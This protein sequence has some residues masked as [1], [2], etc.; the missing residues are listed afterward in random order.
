MAHTT[1]Y[2]CPVVPSVKAALA[3]NKHW[4]QC[5]LNHT[6]DYKANMYSKAMAITTASA[7]VLCHT[8]QIILSVFYM[9]VSF[10]SP[11]LLAF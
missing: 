11:T 6:F 2:I 4:I 9:H 8:M 1:N 7:G 10:T 5:P 3:M